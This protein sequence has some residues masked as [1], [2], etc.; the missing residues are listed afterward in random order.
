LLSAETFCPG[1]TFV[2]SVATREKLSTL[3]VPR[4]HQFDADLRKGGRSLAKRRRVLTNIKT[5]L[6]FA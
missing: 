1:V 3:T 5:M 4:I 6:K 2:D